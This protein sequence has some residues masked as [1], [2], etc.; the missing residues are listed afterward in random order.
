[1]TPLI[2]PLIDRLFYRV[3]WE[4]GKQFINN[5]RD[6]GFP[7]ML[8]IPE[9][10]LRDAGF[11]HMHPLASKR[12]VCQSLIPFLPPIVLVN[13]CCVIFLEASDD[14]NDLL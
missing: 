2:E 12:I 4:G 10:I 6:A 3:K 9:D 14:G 13:Q 8:E 11:F 7:H 5:K 1:M